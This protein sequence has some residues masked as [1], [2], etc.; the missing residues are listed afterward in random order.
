M[1]SHLAHVDSDIA[2]RATVK[3]YLLHDSARQR[4]AVNPS[5]QS[6]F[7]ISKEMK[8]DK[9]VNVMFLFAY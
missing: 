3:L 8:S 1:T 4:C 7:W 2:R 9:L 5:Y 6:V